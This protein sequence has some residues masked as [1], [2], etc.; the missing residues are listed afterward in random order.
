MDRELYKKV[1]QEHS[2][3]RDLMLFRTKPAVDR[4]G[5]LKMGLMGAGLLF[6]GCGGGSS[7]EENNST[8]TTSNSETNTTTTSNTTGSSEANTTTTNTTTDTTTD[9]NSKCLNE[10]PEET[11]GPYP[12]DGSNASNQTLNVLDDAGI[13]RKDI[14]SSLS[15]GNTAQGTP[16]S[17][18]LKLSNTSGTCSSLEGYAVY[19][20]H[21]NA[22]GEY[23]LYGQGITNED[24]LRGVQVTNSNGEV[25]FTTIFP[26]CY[27]GRWPHIHFEIYPSL[28]VATNASNKIKT[29]QLALPEATCNTVYTSDSNY[30]DSIGNLSRITLSSD[31]VFGEDSGVLQI[32]T[33]TGDI[34]S[35][36]TATLNVGVK[37]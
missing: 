3:E 6:V 22:Q 28:N 9:I 18:T 23:S 19:I 31:N 35:G 33:I 2:L 11:Q 37:I 34:S 24:Y 20:W 29:S 13:V 12:A 36:L 30:T 8:S 25:T 1:L 16:L 4:R 14:T 32:A 27:S 10:I 26:G 7:S 21:C 15:T 17:V 5:M